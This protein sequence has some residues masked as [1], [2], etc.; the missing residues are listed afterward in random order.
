MRDLSALRR[1]VIR[2]RR[3]GHP[4]WIDDMSLEENRDVL[5]DLPFTGIKLDRHLVGA[6]P[7]RRRARGEMERLVAAAGARGMAVT[8][9]GVTDA[10]L[11]RAVEAAGVDYA[12]GFGVGR[13]LPAAA[14]SA[15]IAA[16]RG[17]RSPPAER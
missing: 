2:L 12:Q 17:S 14:L 13:P 5:L 11:W 6:L 10:V 4:V 1:A 16:W 3:A 7:H 9:E 8:A 15:W